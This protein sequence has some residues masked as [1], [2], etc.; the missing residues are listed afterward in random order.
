MKILVPKTLMAHVSSGFGSHKRTRQKGINLSN[1]PCIEFLSAPVR[2]SRLAKEVLKTGPV[3]GHLGQGGTMW[4]R[5]GVSTKHCEALKGDASQKP[6]WVWIK[7][8]ESSQAWPVWFAKSSTSLPNQT[9]PSCL[10]VDGLSRS[11]RP[12]L[13]GLR[14]RNRTSTPLLLSFFGNAAASNKHEHKRRNVLFSTCSSLFHKKLHPPHT[15][16]HPHQVHFSL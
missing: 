9:G 2:P 7:S 3:R 15:I 10:P 12:G 14:W 11:V 4:N 16:F 8:M 13:A 1:L 5:V 6:S